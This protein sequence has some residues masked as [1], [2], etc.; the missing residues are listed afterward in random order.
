MTHGENNM[1]HGAVVVFSADSL[2]VNSLFGFLVSFSARKFCRYCE[3]T[4]E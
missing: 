2:G 4:K 3:A 1:V